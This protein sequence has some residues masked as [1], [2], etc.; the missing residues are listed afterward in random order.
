M[1]KFPKFVVTVDE[2]REECFR[3]YKKG[4]RFEFRDFTYPPEG[5]CAG[6]LHSIFP[7][8][9]AM[10]FGAKFPFMKEKNTMYTTCPDGKKITFK[11]T[12]LPEEELLHIPCDRPA[13]LEIEVAEVTGKCF[14]QYKKGDKFK[15]K[16][17]STPPGFCGAA[18]SVL[19]P[20]LFNLNFGGAYPFEEDVNA[21]TTT[22]CPDGGYVRFKTKRIMRK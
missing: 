15:L 3:G 22:T 8:M 18:Y 2:V 17:L 14:Y 20:V 13:D 4:D 12:C 10:T 11:I 16:G 19:F 1:M 6:A 9:Y 7:V 21:I 5:F